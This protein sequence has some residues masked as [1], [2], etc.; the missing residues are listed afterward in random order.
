MWVG[1]PF[2]RGGAGDLEFR[3]ETSEERGLLEE[4]LCIKVAA[5]NSQLNPQMPKTAISFNVPPKLWD[6]FKAQADCRGS[7]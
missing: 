1:T 7:I 6:A 4:N 5:I 3:G 2:A